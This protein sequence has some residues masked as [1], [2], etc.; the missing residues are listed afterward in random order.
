MQFCWQDTRTFAVGGIAPRLI[1]E[2]HNLCKDL[3]CISTNHLPKILNFPIETLMKYIG[4][5]Y[6]WVLCEGM[7]SYGKGMGLLSLTSLSIRIHPNHP[8][9]SSNLC[10]LDPKGLGC[11][12][13]LTCPHSGYSTHTYLPPHV[14]TYVVLQVSGRLFQESCV[15]RG[16]LRRCRDA[17]K[18]QD[19]DVE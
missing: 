4:P 8:T 17:L 6:F 18:G 16:H 12:Q 7:I 15:P 10:C 2:S 5:V 19:V 13:L 1:F 14:P 11:Q 9:S 3:S